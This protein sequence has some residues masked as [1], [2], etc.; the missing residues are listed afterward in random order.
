MHSIE[1]EISTITEGLTDCEKSYAAYVHLMVTELSQI[2]ESQ[3]LRIE[4]ACIA[5]AV[6]GRYASWAKQVLDWHYDDMSS[7]VF[8]ICLLGKHRRHIKAR[9]ETE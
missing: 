6:G 7:I 4:R 3:Y 5:R 8:E 2:S 1:E 9:K